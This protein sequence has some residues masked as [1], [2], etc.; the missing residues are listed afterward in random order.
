MFPICVPLEIS[1][2]FMYFQFDLQSRYQILLGYCVSR[3]VPSC[4]LARS[5][6]PPHASP[7]PSFSSC[8]CVSSLACVL[9]RDGDGGNALY[10]ETVVSVTWTGNE[11]ENVHENA[12]V[13]CVARHRESRRNGKTSTNAMRLMP[14]VNLASVVKSYD[15]NHE[16]TLNTDIFW[17][18]GTIMFPTVAFLA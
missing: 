3:N 15:L 17:T 6:A 14:S 5:D 12:D 8:L 11:S 1:S 16:R 2:V 9:G 10:S 4:Q 7:S 18:T 13:I